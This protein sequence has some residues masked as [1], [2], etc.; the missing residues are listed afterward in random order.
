MNKDILY[1]LIQEEQFVGWVSQIDYEKAVVLTN[2]LW[3]ARARGIP[4]NC[5][6]LATSLEPG[7]AADTGEIVLLRVIGSRPMATD[8]KLSRAR[9]E[10]LK[11]RTATTT[12]RELD[13]FTKSE[14]QFGSFECRVLGTFYNQQGTLRLGSDIESYYNAAELEVYRP[15][16]AALEIIVNYISPERI[17]AAAIEARKLGLKGALPRFPIG[18]VRFTSTDRIHRGEPSERV[19]FNLNAI[20]FLAR[21]TGVFGMTRTGKSNMVK[22]LV[23]VVMRTSSQCGLKIGQIIYDLNGEYANA[24]Q[25]DKGAIAEVYPQN[26]V[27]YRVIPTSGFQPILNNFY[28]QITEGH[29]TLRALIE[30][31]GVPRFAD[32]EAFLSIVFDEPGREEFEDE[33]DWNRRLAHHQKI[34]AAYQA[35]L[36]RAGF[37]LPK[38][39]KIRFE[40]GGVVRKLVNPSVDPSDGLT[41][42][43]AVS[44][45]DLARQIQE[46]L[47]EN[48]QPW[49]DPDTK[50]LVNMLLQKNDKGAY[51]AGYRALQPYKDY[52]SPHRTTEVSDEIYRHLLDGKIVILDLSVGDTTQRG[53]LSRR[54]AQHIFQS[55]MATFNQGKQPPH[56]VIY[57]EEAHNLIGRDEPLTEVW[58]RIVKEGAKAWIATVYATQEVSSVH[59][60][61]L[62][63]T[64]NFFV[65]HLNNENEFREISRFYDFRDFEDSILRAQDVGFN[66]VKTLSNPFVIPVQ[67]DKFNPDLEKQRAG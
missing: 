45:F 57:V 18:T 5:F 25:Q 11:S 51:I 54:I 7:E 46:Q 65:S 34:V 61:I 37:E 36:A 24:N 27:R 50:A 1:Q 4:H 20:D 43:Q 6:L 48:N 62:S 60:N 9:I 16:T 66:R 30:D 13:D 53:R 29:S 56:I 39:F 8:D 26:T 31:S 28:A 42:E 47:Y 32:L 21:R 2:D 14:L 17:F 67:I 10:N 44:W 52:H 59:P 49:F 63:N 3:K 12:G 41:P 19:V 64:E 35:V 55:S 15:K 22:Q 33:D 58:P 23:S 38:G 40:V